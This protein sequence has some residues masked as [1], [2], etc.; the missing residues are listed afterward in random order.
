MP[1]MCNIQIPKGKSPEVIKKVMVDVSEVL[2][3]DFEA[4]PKQV[5]VIVDELPQTRYI[6]GGVMA[7]EMEEF[8]ET[9]VAGD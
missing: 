3:R 2:M 1:Y 7:T 6:I 8:D 9:D 5:R 4:K